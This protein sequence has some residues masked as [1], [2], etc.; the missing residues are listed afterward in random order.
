MSSLLIKNGIVV[1]AEYVEK[2]DI[3]IKE[4]KIVL[5]ENHISEAADKIIDAKGNYIMPGGIDAHTHMELPVMGTFSSDDFSTGTKAALMGGTTTIIDFANQVRG[6]S[7]RE[8]IDHWYKKA[9]DKVYCD[10]G[11]HLSVTEVNDKTIAELPKIISEDGITSFKTFLAYDAMKL[12]TED[13]K[14]LM[15]E[16]Q[17][18][19]AMVTTHAENGKMVDSLIRKHLEEGKTTPNYHPLSRPDTAES[20]ATGTMMMLAKET[21]CP[22]YIVHM[23]CKGAVNHLRHARESGLPVLGETCPQYL[24]LDESLYQNT[25]FDQSARFVMS[26]PL[27]ARE[28]RDA[29][30]RALRRGDIAVVATDHCPFTLEQ[31]R[32]GINNFT[33]IPNGAPGVEDRME[34]LYTEGVENRL[35]DLQTYVKVTSTNPAKIFGIYPQKGEIAIGS[36]ADLVLID[37]S[38][39]HELKAETQHM[40]VDYNCYQGRILKGKIDKV[41]L[42]GVL[43]VDADEFL[44]TSPCG[45]YLK[46]KVTNINEF[47]K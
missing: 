5:V 32:A 22:T 16:I 40:R 1:T 25:N 11:L 31:K 34:L 42:A 2:K 28:D 29:L 23:T 33:K 41:L 43:A 17:K 24:L 12:S 26:P 3:L 46:R 35:I 13:L 18:L 19:G 39:I 47:I 44:L 36:D 45:R 14:R 10:Y 38:I 37:P 8:T 21:N 30:W 6:E 4:G 20:D 15:I 9:N 7:L 27:R